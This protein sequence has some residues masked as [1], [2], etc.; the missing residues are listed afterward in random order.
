M[1]TAH[2]SNRPGHEYQPTIIESRTLLRRL[3]IQ[4]SFAKKELNQG[5]IDCGKD[6]VVFTRRCARDLFHGFKKLITTPNVVPSCAAAFVVVAFLVTLALLIERSAPSR[7]E[8]A[9]KEEESQLVDVVYFDLSRRTDSIGVGG[10]GRVGFNKGSGEGSDPVRKPAHGGGGGGDRTLLPQQSGK[11]PPP[12]DVH[13]SIPTHPPL[14]PPSLPAAG[15]D[16]DPALWRD[17]PA[18]VYGDPRTTS[19]LVSKG[20]GEGDGMGTGKG[21]GIGE[22]D[23]PGFGPGRDGNIGDGAKENGGGGIGGGRGGGMSGTV[24]RQSEVEQRARLLSKPEPKY[25]EDARR[26]GVTGTVMLRVI[27]SSSGEVVQIQAVQKLPY[28]LTEQA[29]AAARE[30]KFVPAAK[31]GRPVSVS[32][33]LEYNFNLY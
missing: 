33:Q 28:G 27:F 2:S 26:N 32:M 12:S 14:N 1:D 19:N 13:A 3:A 29:I 20:P 4:I 11:V 8:L 15:I 25:T 24:L 10:Q 31:G 30:I 16:L 22:G 21:L 9:E 7:D 17:L 18:P 5:W 23:G 6:P